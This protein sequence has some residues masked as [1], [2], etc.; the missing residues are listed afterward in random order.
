MP[1]IT[2]GSSKGGCGK[3]TTAVILADAFVSE[4]LRVRLIDADPAKRVWLWSNDKNGERPELLTVV[5]AT[6]DTLE[7]EIA[8]GRREADVTIVDV[9]GSRNLSLLT[10]AAVSDLVLI[11]AGHS[12]LDAADAVKTA[13][14]IRLLES[15]ERKVPHGVVWTRVPTFVS[16]EARAVEGFVEAANLPVIGRVPELTAFKAVFSFGRVTSLLD[17]KAVRNKAKAVEVGLDLAAACLTF[18]KSSKV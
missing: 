18:I 7:D 14:S 15:G 17:A 10:A 2:L 4:G 11:P 1:V 3:S 16:G 9:E 6:E 13:K 5:L 8:A 12:P